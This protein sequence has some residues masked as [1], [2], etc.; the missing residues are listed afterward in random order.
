MLQSYGLEWE[1]VSIL[2]LFAGSGSLGFEALSRGAAQVWFLE[3]DT[4][5]AKTI[6]GNLEALDVSR[7]RTRI[8]AKDL[9]SILGQRQKLD[10]PPVRSGVCRP[11]IWQEPFARALRSLV[12]HGWM[13]PGA[14]I[15]AEVEASAPAGKLADFSNLE[16]LKDRTY[17]QTRIVLWKITT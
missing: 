6:A 5:A 14:L 1:S 9:F 16:L 10:P 13:A 4:R 11:P 15:A 8:L 17:G 2:D 7:T 3:Q 12:E